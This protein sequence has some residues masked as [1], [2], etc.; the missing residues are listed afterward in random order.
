LR[1]EQEIRKK[2]N[3]LSCYLDVKTIFESSQTEYTEI[4]YL[5]DYFPPQLLNRYLI[6]RTFI[7][8]ILSE[9]QKEISS[10]TNNLFNKISSMVKKTKP[11]IVQEN[12]N[13]LRLNLTNNEILKKN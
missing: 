1:L 4:N 7:Q 12:L 6:E 11:E 3:Y 8:N 13:E 10:K 2:K 5:K 9:I